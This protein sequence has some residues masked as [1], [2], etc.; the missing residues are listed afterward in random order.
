MEWG[1]LELALMGCDRPDVDIL[2]A[3]ADRALAIA[4]EFGDHDLEVLALA[5]GGL[6]LITQ[7]RI[8]E[9]FDRLDS[10]M[11]AIAAG[12]VADFGLAGQS[13]CSMLT[14]CDRAGDVNRVEEWVRVDTRNDARAH[15]RSAEGARDALPAGV[16]VGRRR[17]GT[18]VGG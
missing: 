18:V 13:F 10:A 2:E 7:G 16:R 8:R 17:D 12:E 3:S 4:L 11:A 14:G 9:G 5:D 6:A 15:R 1:Y